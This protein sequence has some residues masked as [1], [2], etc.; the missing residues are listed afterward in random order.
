MLFRG[1]IRHIHVLS[2]HDMSHFQSNDPY[3]VISVS[4]P[5]SK[6]VSLRSC[7][8]RLDVLSLQFHDLDYS[9][10]RGGVLFTES[11][12]SQI[13]NFVKL[14]PELTTI[15][16]HCEAGISRSAGIGA[17]ISKFYNGNDREFYERRRP[18][19]RVY[20]LLLNAFM[21]SEAFG[22]KTIVPEGPLVGVG[23]IIFKDDSRKQVLMGLRKSKLGDG[24]WAFPGGHME[25]GETPE[26]TA[27]RETL[28]E[29]GLV[30]IPDNN[31]R[32]YGYTKTIYHDL[33]KH[34]ITLYVACKLAGGVLENKEPDKC[35]RWEWVDVEN[36]PYPLME[37]LPDDFKNNN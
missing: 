21:D 22:G 18:N 17:A 16:V 4:D 12:A 10:D 31:S 5:G 35:D 30:V 27:I 19:S 3:I 26:E 37:S 20:S 2:R 25:W 36:L 8:N 13:V 33:K 23:A 29:T 6:R 11:D 28:E 1:S 9:S 32:R 15:V 14:W 24:C 34:Y 7:P